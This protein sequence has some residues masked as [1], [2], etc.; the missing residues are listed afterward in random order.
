MV[1]VTE[2]ATVAAGAPIKR[3]CIK[4]GGDFYVRMSGPG[5]KMKYCSRACQQ[6]SYRQRTA[7]PIDNIRRE[8]E[9]ALQALG[10]RI[11]ALGAEKID[12]EHLSAVVRHVRALL[13][14]LPDYAVTDTQPTAVETRPVVAAIES[15]DDAPDSTR[16]GTNSTPAVAEPGTES[17]TETP[18][19]ETVRTAA[20]VRTALIGGVRPTSEQ[21]AIIDACVSGRNLV[22][23][24]G[25]GTGKTSTLRMAA[26]S[27]PRGRRGLYVA[28]NKAVAAEAK[29]K[30]PGSVTCA[31][32]HS[33][34]YR[35]LGYAYKQRLNGPRVPAREVAK[36]MK[37]TRPL[38]L[39]TTAGARSLDPA[40]LAR[41]AANT[42]DRYCMSADLEIAAH[43]VPPVNGI[44]GI[45]QLTLREFILPKAVEMWEEL[46]GKRGQLRFAHDY[47]LKMWA[48]T[49]P[50]LGTDVVFFDE[51]QDANPVIARV[52]QAQ[53]A[54]LV[55]V[56]DSNQAIYAWRG[57][58][59]ALENWPADDRLRLSQ[60]W[61][62]GPAIADEANK[63]LTALESDLRLT[64]TPSVA[65]SI[66]TLSTPDAVLC[67]T[68]AAAMGQ[69]IEAMDHG[70]R[71]ALVGG[72]STVKGLAE[73]A[74]DLQAGRTTQHPELAAFASWSDVQ[75]YVEQDEAG[76]DLGVFVRL[77]DQHGAAELIRAAS[78]LVNEDRAQLTIS[79]AHKAKGREW[80]RVQ[81]AGDFRQPKAD[82]DGNPGK[83]SRPEA[84]LA[85][86]SVTRAQH[87]LDR[88]GLAWIDD[89]LAGV[90]GPS[91]RRK[92]TRMT[93][94][95]AAFW[96]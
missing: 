46:Q 1:D 58:I 54:Q 23:E 57:A 59:D 52:V 44:D 35:A 25:A 78:R 34:A 32:A 49:N 73:A 30:F 74:Q 80:H 88:G 72:G 3:Q 20:A 95:S 40:V 64:G 21:A 19:K 12:E 89:H 81:A 43:H 56:G 50:D 90:P 31:T 55:A 7:L 77:V 9:D 79:T 96:S 51:A 48:L 94:D 17:V 27:L 2:N 37:I 39:T 10:P 75:D 13:D 87:V 67:R 68:N 83:L 41:I 66:A 71:V 11:S 18:V 63:W 28:F 42:V 92:P 33:L 26:L 76:A 16:T 29:S 38:D 14:L 53:R 70:R 47:Y 65:S 69:A 84:M 86:V 8:A 85:Y 4:C 60:S 82:D 6:A 62:F 24:A 15:H 36:I 91:A 5:R 61:R 93:D 22:I 45:A